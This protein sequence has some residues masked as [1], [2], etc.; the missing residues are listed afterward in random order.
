MSTPDTINFKCPVCEKLLF[1]Q[2]NGSC[3]DIDISDMCS[4]QIKM[5]DL[6]KKVVCGKCGVRI[7]FDQR[8]VMKRSFILVP[9]PDPVIT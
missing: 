2:I 5:V 8:Q 9:V 3:S 4:C 7:A 6:S 1:F